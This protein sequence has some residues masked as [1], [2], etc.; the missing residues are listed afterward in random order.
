MHTLC[1]AHPGQGVFANIETLALPADD[2]DDWTNKH[3]RQTNKQKQ[4]FGIIGSEFKFA[5]QM[6]KKLLFSCII[7][8]KRVTK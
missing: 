6:V 5:I 2:K 4:E 8:T 3:I 7:S 1:I